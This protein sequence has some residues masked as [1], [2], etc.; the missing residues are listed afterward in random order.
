MDMQ[1]TFTMSGWIRPSIWPASDLMS[2]MS[3]DANYEFHVDP[4]GRINWWWGGGTQSLFT[5]N[6]TAP[7]NQWTFVAVVFTRGSQNVY[8]GNTTTVGGGVNG[9]DTQQLTTNT[10]QMQIGDDQ[11]F[12]SGSRRWSGLIDDI[13][14]YDYAL[15]Q[16]E[17][18]AIRTSNMPCAVDHYRIQNNASGV[19]CQAE[20][21]TVTAHDALHNPISMNSATTISLTHRSVRVRVAPVAGAIGRSSPA[22][23]R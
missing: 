17:V 22:A 5:P 6:N 14:V 23:A 12:G 9:A 20:T 3:K 21:V 16:S 8:L 13:R 2:F 19:N 10:L 7:L 4:T 18:D 1:S 15:T 11:D